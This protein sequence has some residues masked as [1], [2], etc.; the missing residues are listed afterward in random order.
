MQ[1][2][3]EV[4]A[5]LAVSPPD[6]VGHVCAQKTSRFVEE[7]LVRIGQLDVGEIHRLAPVLPLVGTFAGGND[8]SDP[9]CGLTRVTS[10][11]RPTPRSH[12]ILRRGGLRRNPKPA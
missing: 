6:L 11:Q 3:V 1:T 12:Q 8:L 10:R 4:V 5:G 7:S 2:L 9:L